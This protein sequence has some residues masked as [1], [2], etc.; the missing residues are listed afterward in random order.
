MT[1]GPDPVTTTGPDLAGED[2]LDVIWAR[3][4]LAVS[5]PPGDLVLAPASRGR[6]SQP[7]EV[8]GCLRR[9]MCLATA[10]RSFIT[11]AAGV[12]PGTL[13]FAT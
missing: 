8:T 10:L 6:V 1:T 7:A 12:Y 5:L 11:V 9:L 4:Y 13:P 2:L 3:Y